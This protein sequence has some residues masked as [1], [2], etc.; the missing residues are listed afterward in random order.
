LREQARRRGR[1]MTE[2]RSR[3]KSAQ[4]KGYRGA[5]QSHRQE[6]IAHKGAM[7]EL[8]KRA[9][10][11]IFKE[12]NKNRKEG[13]MIDLHGLLVAEAIEFAKEELQ[14]A[15]SR[16]D[17]VVRFIVGKG[18]HSEDGVAKIR[19]ALETFC[20]KYV[21]DRPGSEIDPNNEGVLVVHLPRQN[22]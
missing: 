15:K 8:D 19:P 7:E 6:A 2:A 20:T 11:I 16:G 21:M 12:K 10:K 1:E 5:A 17:E 18:L 14:S 3:A 22:P 4:K 9:A 13:G